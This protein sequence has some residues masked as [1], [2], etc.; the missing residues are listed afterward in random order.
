VK[1]YYSFKDANGKLIKKETNWHADVSFDA[2][3]KPD[4]TN[5]QVP[6]TPVAILTFGD[7]KKLLFNQ[8]LG[9]GNKHPL[10]G[11]QIDF[12]Q[13]NARL[14]ILH[15][16]DEAIHPKTNTHWKHMSEMITDDNLQAFVDGKMKPVPVEERVTFSLM[17]RV[18][19][20]T[21]P[22]KPL[23]DRMKDVPQPDRFL[24]GMHFFTSKHYITEHNALVQKM[25]GLFARKETSDTKAKELL[26][27][28]RAL[29]AARNMNSSDN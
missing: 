19:Q 12:K 17:L 13:V 24:K 27:K 10:E 3:G 1:I 9:N 25:N 5:S 11:T 8:Y 23:D 28:K 16:G 22:V 18:V 21:C 14:F 6:G 4:K 2:N 7:P 29:L 20:V 15:P 26:P